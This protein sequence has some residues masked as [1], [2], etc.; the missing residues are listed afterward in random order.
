MSAPKTPDGEVVP[1]TTRRNW[2]QARKSGLGASETA[3]ILGLSQ[4]SRTPYDV[5]LDKMSDTVDES[6]NDAMIWGT[7]LEPVIARR[8]N[9]LYRHRIGYVRPNPGLLRS[10]EH[11]WMLATIDRLLTAKARDPIALAPLEIKTSGHYMR[12][13]WD[14]GVP[15]AYQVQVQ[16]Q[17][18][19]SGLK[20]GWLVALHEGRELSEPYRIPR[21]DRVI[22]QI[23]TYVGRW[24]HE[25][26]EL[27]VPPPLTAPDYDKLSQI[28]RGVPALEHICSEVERANIGM[29][30]EVRGQIKD[31]EEYEAELAAKVKISLGDATEALD[32]DGQ[33]LATWRSFERTSFDKKQLTIDHPEIVEQYSYKTPY[34]SFNLK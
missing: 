34:R 32:E 8:V 4:F 7:L 28:W 22:E 17:L 33:L 27:R 23:V 11:P 26:V 25:Y 24:W 6:A 19:V 9:T 18:A 14:N 12:K 1:T 16:Q 2:L 30:R 3:V 13:H 21:D 5:W 20:Y 10:T 15:N 29:L 31:L